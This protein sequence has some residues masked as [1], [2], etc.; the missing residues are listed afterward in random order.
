VRVTGPGGQSLDSNADGFDVSPGGKIR[1]MR[2]ADPDANFTVVGLQNARPG[3]YTVSLLPGSVPIT[4]ISR[5]SD[6]PAA[7][8]IGKV[9]G[10]GAQRVLHYDVKR[11][12]DQ[13]VTFYDIAQGGSG[14]TIG[15]PIAGG[16]GSL[17]FTPSPGRGLHSVFAR[18]EL[19]GRPAE[20]LRIARFKPPSPLLARPGGLQV[21]RAKSGSLSVSWK[22][23]P[24]ATRYEIVVTKSLGGQRLLTT[25][26]RRVTVGGIPKTVSGR[27]S[28]R[29]VAKLREGA[30]AQKPFRRV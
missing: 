5:A 23:V 6:P 25:R 26:G 4:G 1:I 19:N 15:K 27:V 28:V 13:T 29:A 22:A 9:T 16:R 10:S 3:T 30:T 17:H 2:I 18:F 14:K 7:K 8:A 20:Q 21:K 12:P 11:R 24:G